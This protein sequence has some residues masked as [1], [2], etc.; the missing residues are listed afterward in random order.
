MLLL[1]DIIRCVI[2]LFRTHSMLVS[3]ADFKNLSDQN[4]L[5]CECEVVTFNIWTLLMVDNVL[6]S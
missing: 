3:K 4:Y 6:V 1:F 2:S 5:H